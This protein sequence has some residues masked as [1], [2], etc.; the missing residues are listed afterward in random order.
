MHGEA[1]RTRRDQP[2]HWHPAEVRQV[3]FSAIQALTIVPLAGHCL[4]AMLID[5]SRFGGSTVAPLGLSLA[6]NRSKRIGG[7]ADRFV[8]GIK[9]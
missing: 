6:S 8:P 2:W 9:W 1:V 5:V 4:G 3:P 7:A